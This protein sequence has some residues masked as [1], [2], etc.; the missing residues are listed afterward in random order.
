VWK[1]IRPQDT[2]AV[3]GAEATLHDIAPDRVRR[4]AGSAFPIV[5][6]LKHW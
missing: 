2:L 3:A 6:Y 4:P 5:H 1:T